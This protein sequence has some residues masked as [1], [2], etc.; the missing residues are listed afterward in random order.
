MVKDRERL[1]TARVVRFRGNKKSV[2]R[3]PTYLGEKIVTRRRAKI[4]AD[5]EERSAER[6]TRNAFCGLSEA[7]VSIE[8]QG[9]E[10]IHTGVKN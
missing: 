10:L 4:E 3:S 5:R 2:V 1:H 8:T 9:M 7:R 6:S